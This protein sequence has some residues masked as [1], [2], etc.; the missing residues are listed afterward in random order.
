MNSGISVSQIR[1]NGA[2]YIAETR[3][4]S[5]WKWKTVIAA[6]SVGNPLFY[7][8]SIGIGVGVL[9]NNHSG[10]S[11]TGGVKYIVFLAPALLASTAVTGA[12]DEV[13]FPVMEGFKWR[14]LFYGMSATPISGPQIA[15]GVLLAAIARVIF[16]VVV[17]W[18]LLLAFGILHFGSSWLVVPVTIFG[19]GAFGAFILGLTS[20]VTNEDNFMNVMG[21][22]VITPL[23]LFSGTFFP[24]TS[25]PKFIQPLGWISPL[26]H[27]TELGRY[28]SYNYSISGLLLFIHFTYL[29]ALWIIGISIANKKFVARL[30]K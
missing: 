12:M 22:L 20:R 27:T 4:R 8:I 17:Y 9:V 23:F 5:L 25:M 24:L 21:R 11:G 3:I 18:A 29:I 6:V 30:Y 10:T 13:M 28:F 7:L 14:R 2:L 19:G 15:L 1:R 26:W 16:A